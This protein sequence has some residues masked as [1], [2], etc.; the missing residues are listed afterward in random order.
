MLTNV[1]QLRL[2]ALSIFVAVLV[3]GIALN[4]STRRGV[5]DV[6]LM[7]QVIS[8][9]E[10]LERYKYDFQSYPKT[11]DGLDVRTAVLS[12]HG[13]AEGTMVYYRGVM[14]SGRSVIY[15]S[16]GTN[17]TIRFR[18]RRTWHASAVQ[19]KVCTVA[20]NVKLSCPKPS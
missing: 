19:G 13:F 12:D 11:A 1:Q 7:T 5:Q 2:Y 16:D 17:Y 9:A 18:L 20:T 6:Q 4:V 8:F 15:S 10:S 14:R 3:I